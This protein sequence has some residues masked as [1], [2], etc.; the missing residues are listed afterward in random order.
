MATTGKEED[1]MSGVRF[2]APEFPFQKELPPQFYEWKKMYFG[3]D[4]QA[5]YESL[6]EKEK[7]Y[8]ENTL[9]GWARDRVSVRLAYEPSCGCNYYS[10]VLIDRFPMSPLIIYHKCV[11]CKEVEYVK[12]KVP[13]LFSTELWGDFTLE[14]LK[15]SVINESWQKPYLES[16]KNLLCSSSVTDLNRQHMKWVNK[17]EKNLRKKYVREMDSKSD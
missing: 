6:S 16:F 10:W 14:D 13:F 15:N 9:N 1:K 4:A 3:L 2:L 7:Y 8:I 12:L 17:H 11:E 5:K